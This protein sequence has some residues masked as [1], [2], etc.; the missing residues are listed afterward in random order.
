MVSWFDAVLFCNWLS[1]NEGLKPCYERTGRR[2]QL[3]DRD[4]EV[5]RLVQDSDGYRLPTE[6]E[7]EYACRAGT[8]TEYACGNDG[9]FLGGYAVYDTYRPVPSG[10]KVP[11]GW[12]LFDMHGNVW[13]WCDKSSGKYG[14]EFATRDRPGTGPLRGGSFLNTAADVRSTHRV[15]DPLD[16]RAVTYGFRPARTCR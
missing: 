9:A 10:S 15:P 16:Q 7:W 8:I 2:Q 1:H 6:A 3:Y 11:N 5:W 4:W 12:G 14:T 13:E